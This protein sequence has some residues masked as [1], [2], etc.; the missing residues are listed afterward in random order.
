MLEQQA[1]DSRRDRPHDEQPG[2]LGVRVVLA[3]AAVAQAAAEPLHDPHPVV[4]E[5]AEQHE[6]R[7]EMRRD[8][9]GD[10][11]VVV[12]VDVPP[13]ELRQ[14]HAVAEAR[15]R[16]KLGDALEQAEEDRLPVR[17]ERRRDGQVGDVRFSPVWN[18][19]YTR[20][21]APSRNAAIPCLTW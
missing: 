3:D 18:H 11:V 7:R 10:E 14:D 13:E 19:A 17:D 16:E 5:E 2:E 21:A 1:E 9:E 8:E 6:R 12:L 20:H 4:P 15:D